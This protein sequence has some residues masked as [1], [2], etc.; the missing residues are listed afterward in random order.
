MTR[1]NLSEKN[2]EF[3]SLSRPIKKKKIENTP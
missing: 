2:E 1:N 3:F